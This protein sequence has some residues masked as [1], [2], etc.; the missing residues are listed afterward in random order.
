[1]V[2]PIAILGL[3]IGQTSKG[4]A[5]ASSPLLICFDPPIGT[6][7]QYTYTETAEVNGRKR[8][9]ST[10]IPV[11]ARRR[12][13]DITQLEM[14]GVKWT[15]IEGRS[16]SQEPYKFLLNR[17]G[18]CDRLY[19]LDNFVSPNYLDFFLNLP[20]K[21]LTIGQSCSYKAQREFVTI[22]ATCTCIKVEKVGTRN[23]AYLTQKTKGTVPKGSPAEPYEFQAHLW[24]D[25]DRKIVAKC[26]VNTLRIE[27]QHAAVT[28]VASDWSK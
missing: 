2:V 15:D 18:L 10:V 23:Y 21:K 1:M 17:N 20:N 22:S 9:S 12:N 11:I 26:V 25:I 5:P 6:E 4:S 3:M 8:V 14:L 13:R 16:H 7:I 27:N 19:R 28:I 24:Y